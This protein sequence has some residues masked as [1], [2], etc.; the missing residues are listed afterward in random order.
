MAKSKQVSIPAPGHLTGTTKA[1]WE[2]VQQTYGICDQTGLRLLQG[3]C[4]QL[5][6]AEAARLAIAKSGQ[7]FTDR[8]GNV[9][10]RP[11]VKIQKDAMLTFRALMRELRL[12]PM[13]TEAR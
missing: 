7:V 10:P 3:A 13:P 4:E 12:D 9:R 5:D 8:L 1:F 11:E 2:H 6:V